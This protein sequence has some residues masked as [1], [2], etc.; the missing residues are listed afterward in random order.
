MCCHCLFCFLMIRRPPR[1]TR[2]DT[3]FPYS[4]LVRSLRSVAQAV[5]EDCITTF[6]NTVERLKWH[7]NTHFFKRGDV[8]AGFMFYGVYR[9]GRFTVDDSKKFIPGFVLIRRTDTTQVAEAQT[10]EPGLIHPKVFKDVFGLARYPPDLVG[11]AFAIGPPGASHRAPQDRA[12]SSDSGSGELLTDGV[13]IRYNSSFNSSTTGRPGRDESRQMS[14]QMKTR[15]REFLIG[16][17]IKEQGGEAPELP[18]ETPAETPDR[19]RVEKEK[20][21]SVSVELGGR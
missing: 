1:S 8:Y 21:V 19:K 9:S 17:W 4:T 11:E 3:L 12:L 5:T 2:T 14:P 20:S 13:E 16:R 7:K 10:R 15:L 6:W 18:A